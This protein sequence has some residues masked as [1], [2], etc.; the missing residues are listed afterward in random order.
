MC[1]ALL[2]M[3]FTIVGFL[4]T[5]FSF[6]ILNDSYR[7]FSFLIFELNLFYFLWFYL[8][9]NFFLSY[10][11]LCHFFLLL[12]INNVHQRRFFLFLIVR[13]LFLSNYLSLPLFDTTFILPQIRWKQI[14]KLLRHTNTII[15][16]LYFS[17]VIY[18]HSFLFRFYR[19]YLLIFC[20]NLLLFLIFLWFF[21]VFHIFWI[22]SWFFFL[23][24]P[25]FLFVL[26]LFIWKF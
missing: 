7:F 10:L 16:K 2:R 23:S 4:F 12:R 5:F 11:C 24:L 18:C 15:R 9:V 1:F 19:L 8:I 21:N 22:F 3:T 26:L 14:I 6:I 20:I 25:L 13:V 17:F